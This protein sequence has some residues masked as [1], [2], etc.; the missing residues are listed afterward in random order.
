MSSSESPSVNPWLR[1]AIA[2][3]AARGNTLSDGRFQVPY[4]ALEALLTEWES[5][6]ARH[7]VTREGP[8]VLECAASV[9]GVLT[10][11][12]LLRAGSSFALL[13]PPAR[14]GT[15]PPPPRFFPLRVRVRSLY[16]LEPNAP[17][18]PE[19]LLEV[20]SLEGAR[21]PPEG[22]A[23][24]PGRLFLRTSGSLGTP[25]LVVHS[26]ALLL[27][28][29]LHCVERLRL[30][31]EDLICLPVPIAH[32]YGLGAGL[33]PGLAAGASIELLEG[34]NLPR[35]LEREAQVR[36]TV[37]FLTPNLCTMLLRRRT[38]PGHYR[39][40]VVAGDKL[41]PESFETAETLF[42]RVVNLYGSTELG[43]IATADAEEARG[44]RSTTVG[45]AVPGAG[46]QLRPVEGSQDFEGEV[47]EL[48]C[49]HPFPFLGYVDEDGQ[50]W[51]GE[52]PFQDG[53]YRTKDL[54]RLH[55][56]GLLEVLGRTDHGVKRDGR[57]VMLTDLER[58]V[59]RVPGVERAIAV[60]GGESLRGQRLVVFCVPRD[61]QPLEGDAVRTACFE[62][63]PAYAIPDEVRP[64]ATLPLLPSGKVDRKA[65]REAATAPAPVSPSQ[66]RT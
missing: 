38:A 18:S 56:D 6:L 41:K 54:C 61:G 52:P 12:A 53:W 40:V 36:P 65:L 13:P 42:R 15:P 34:A 46:I 24:A 55:A 58:T 66:E 29:A 1:G 33:L 17:L 59:E 51:Q 43:V 23:G 22:E 48:W 35:F 57:L 45:R 19:A 8:V 2:A 21:S 62:L 64:L 26:Q 7:G 30:T 37:A 47:G 39:H 4:A 63:L 27:G 49:R 32:M 28:N 50:P 31:A 14:T 60:L 11:L 9:P 16:D 5:F 44:P 25:K 10:V 3:G 20:T